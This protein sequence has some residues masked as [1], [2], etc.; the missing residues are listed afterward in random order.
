MR[1][2]AGLRAARG[3]VFRSLSERNYRRFFAGHS[4]SVVGTWMQRIGQDWLVLE[5][6][7][8]AFALGVS[9]VCQFL[10]VLVGGVWGGVVVDRVDTRRLL[11]V[12][13][14]AQAVLAAALAAFSLTGTA[15]LPIV[16]GLAA[17]L[18]I[19]TVFDNPARHTFVAELVGEADIVNAQALNS[20]VN[21]AG[22]LAGPALAGALIVLVGVG[23]TFV[24]NAVS[25]LAVLVALWLMDVGTLRR[26]PPVPRAPGQARAGLRYVWR[27][28]ELRLAIVLVAV[29]SVFGQ[30]FRVVFP[31]LA[32][33]VFH[34]DAR[35][36][37]WLTAALGLGAVA[38]GMAAA[39]A[40]T[41]TP[42]RLLLACAA[43][44][45]VNLAVAGAPAL[46]VALAAVVLL[47][48]T[49]M[50]VNTLARALMQLRTAPELRGR[51]MAINGLVFLG[52]TPV[53]GP[54]MGLLCEWW[55][56]RA[57]LLVSGA[58]CLA[59]AVAV[60][61]VQRLARSGPAL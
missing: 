8:S 34:G 41:A 30:N 53:G 54:L 31:I 1:V 36:Y 58:A 61:P 5:L 28:P 21:N 16:Y 32:S 42:R 59:G 18:G 38:G 55:G 56:A 44:G 2:F 6:T 15:T 49:N 9:M 23:V 46:G 10:P 29:V 35:V 39:A 26:R 43:F 24:I 51:V 33:E 7:G 19:V 20:L 22:R 37:G 25:F 52:G 3:R 27:H 40:T 11:M 4:C 60:V 45:A 57:G 47:G 50:V 48:V 13:Q 17:G 14:A 12:T